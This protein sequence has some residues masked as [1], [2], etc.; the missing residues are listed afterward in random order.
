MTAS[1]S[2]GRS[3]R[4][5]FTLI[6]LLVVVAIIALLISILLP[7]LQRAREQAKQT[8]CMSNMRGIGQAFSMYADEFKGVWPAAVDSMGTQNRWPVPFFE[9]RIITEQLYQ[10]DNATGDVL[11]TGDKSI[12]ICPSEVASRTIRD[13]RI[14]NNTVDR[15]E[16]GGSYAYSG[17]IHRNG[18]ILD[19]GT[20]T[21]PPFLNTIER[22][23]QPAAVFA[24]VDNFRPI[25]AVTDF[26]WRFYRDTFFLGYRTMNGDPV[27][28]SDTADRYKVLGA[29]HSGRLNALAYDTHVETQLP[30]DV[31]YRQVSWSYWKQSPTLPPGGK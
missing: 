19:L 7:S 14:P 15:V 22:C 16:I 25:E 31:E 9:A 11:Q 4:R 21:R 1:C 20:A 3:D 18:D 13:W 12:F 29:R 24:L 27:P 28:P 5:A 2:P 10:Y 26:G 30:T 8:V 23:R 17:E 6:E